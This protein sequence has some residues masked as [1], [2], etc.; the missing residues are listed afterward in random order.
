MKSVSIIAVVYNEERRIASF[1]ESFLWSND[2]III[3]K[4]STDNT[5]GIAL[6]YTKNVIDAPY[7][8][9]GDEAQQGLDIAKNEW[10]MILTASD[11][12]HPNLARRIIAQINDP[13]FLYDVISIP[14][15]IFVFGLQDPRRSPWCATS[16][17]LV[18]KR[19]VIHTSRK[20][21]YE[22]G[23]SSRNVYTMHD[24]GSG[25]V[26]HLTHETVDV[27]LE[28]HTRYTRLESM[29]Y[30]DGSMALRESSKELFNAVKFV[31]FKKKSYLLKWDGIA[32]GLAYISYFIMKYLFVWERFNGK[33]TVAYQALR[34]E[35]KRLWD[36]DTR[37][38]F[39]S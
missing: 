21:H 2:V 23:T 9:T 28:R 8:D 33:G 22:S 14:F 26:Y 18:M 11:I 24:D 35:N 10:V 29:G 36:I 20:V 16:K 17:Q 15:R 32:L 19:S 4:S 30:T 37:G 1:L 7:S 34:D 13:T 6:Q 39:P 12:I 3:D 25:A 27:F 38:N 5:K 31:I